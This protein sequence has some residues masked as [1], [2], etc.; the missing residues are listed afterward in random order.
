MLR[1]L[2]DGCGAG[3]ALDPDETSMAGGMSG[4]RGSAPRRWLGV[5]L[6]LGGA[7]GFSS[8]VMCAKLVYENGASPMTLIM[9]RAAGFALL[10]FMVLKA[11]GRS[12][13]LPPT[14]RWKSVLLG[15]V[16]AV[17]SYCFFSS[18]NL[19]PVPLAALTEYTYPIQT[20]L[21]MWLLRR[22]RVG[23]ARLACFFA[24]FAGLA[25]ALD[26]G[27]GVAGA[28]LD[29][30]GV[31]LAVSASM[32]IT[33]MVL[34]GSA[35]MGTVDSRRVTLHTTATVAVAYLLLFALTPLHT[36]WPVTPLGWVLLAAS[37]VLYLGGMLGFFTGI[38]L[39]GPT[40][41]AMLGNAEPVL[42]VTLA[43]PVLGQ[44]L[45]TRQ[46]LG[47]ALVV[48]AIFCMQLLELRRPR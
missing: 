5:V 23:P 13:W 47:A 16:F 15:L 24:A 40:R 6:A 31:A 7:F 44:V 8:G 12:A 14:E 34:F 1:R 2:L 27:A 48:G 29:M 25:L 45:N 28:S 32:L 42:T 43:G 20:V 21:V 11:L 33:V 17:Q 37:S 35:I 30:R 10:L 22:E 41:A 26:A 18:I 36:Q 39:L 38:S 19:I 4:A 9:S 46:W 3:V